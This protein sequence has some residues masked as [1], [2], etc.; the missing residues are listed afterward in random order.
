M[1]SSEPVDVKRSY[2][3]TGMSTDDGSNDTLVY[4]RPI[5]IRYY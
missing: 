2:D 1:I 5:M 4:I 3:S